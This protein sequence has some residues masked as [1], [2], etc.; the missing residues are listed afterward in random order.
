M[1][2]SGAGLKVWLW[3]TES[4]VCEI[5][6]RVR[7]KQISILN[8]TV[9]LCLS[10]CIRERTHDGTTEGRLRS[11]FSIWWLYPP[12]QFGCSVCQ[13]GSSCAPQAALVSQDLP[14]YPRQAWDFS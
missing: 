6:F 1:L 8:S 3:G 7:V 12:L 5:E 9:C 10:L 14:V 13:P 2:A 4:L 11:I